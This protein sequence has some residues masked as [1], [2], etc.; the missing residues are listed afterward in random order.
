MRIPVGY[1]EAVVRFPI[2]AGDSCEP[3]WDDFVYEEPGITARGNLGVCRRPCVTLLAT[4][5]M[6]TSACVRCQEVTT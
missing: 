2:Y 6:G 5:V 3:P 4:A 1:V